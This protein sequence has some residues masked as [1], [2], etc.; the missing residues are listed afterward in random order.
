MNRPWVSATVGVALALALGVAGCADKPG[1]AFTGEVTGAPSV[2]SGA[3]TAT[4]VTQGTE[5]RIVAG[6]YPEALTVAYDENDLVASWDESRAS[7]ITLTGG[8]IRFDGVGGT[9]TSRKVTISQAG[10]YVVS[11]SGRIR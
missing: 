2:A 5:G 1:T 4:T 6:S 3:A 7:F 8:T 11:G 10:T 9:A